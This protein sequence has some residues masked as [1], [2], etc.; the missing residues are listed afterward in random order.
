ME[1]ESVLPAYKL[2]IGMKELTLQLEDALKKEERDKASKIKQKL[3][4]LQRSLGRIL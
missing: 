2:L 3:L 1:K 4:E